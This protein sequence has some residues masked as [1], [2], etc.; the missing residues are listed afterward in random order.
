MHHNCVWRNLQKKTIRVHGVP[1]NIYNFFFLRYLHSEINIINPH[2]FQ[3]IFQK[4][5]IN[6]SGG[7]SGTVLFKISP[8]FY[9]A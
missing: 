3:E 7:T 4:L 5:A 2:F 6:D 8:D 9:T 1:V